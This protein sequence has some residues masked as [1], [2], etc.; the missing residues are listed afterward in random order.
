MTLSLAHSL[1]LSLHS[2]HLPLRVVFWQVSIRAFQRGAVGRVICIFCFKM[3]LKSLKNLPAPAPAPLTPGQVRG[4]RQGCSRADVWP[5]RLK[6][7]DW[8]LHRPQFQGSIPNFQHPGKAMT[9]VEIHPCTLE[10]PLHSDSS[11]AHATVSANGPVMLF[12][13]LT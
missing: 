13:C 2:T 7:L 3:A 4:V 5:P 1:A 11:H 9:E 12:C 6:A 10:Y 8:I